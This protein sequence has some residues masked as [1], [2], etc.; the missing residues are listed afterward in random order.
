MRALTAFRFVLVGSLCLGFAQSA[1]SGDSPASEPQTDA[2]SDN[3]PA[4]QDCDDADPT[5]FPGGVEVCDGRDND[6][7]GSVDE[8][9]VDAQRY[10]ADA[11]EDGFGDDAV[12]ELSC[13][14]PAGHVTKSGD[15]DDSNEAVFPG[16]TEICNDLDDDCD[17]AIDEQIPTD[18]A[19]CLD[20]GTP[21]YSDVVDTVIVS[22]R[23]G[24]GTNDGTNKNKLSLC[25][26]ASDCFPL[27]V[28][29]VDDFRVG[30]MD[31]YH[32]EGLALPRANISSQRTS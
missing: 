5:S 17:E 4:E 7:D 25:L 31:V 18:G 19:G 15:C 30:E 3:W 13:E 22:I 1:C 6:C 14:P 28:L 16:A 2:D 32:F 27:D 11:D 23:T 29:D 26:S 12:S 24:D 20:P 8:E 21:S 9:A 10:Y